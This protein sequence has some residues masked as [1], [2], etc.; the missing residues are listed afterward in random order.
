MVSFYKITQCQNPDDH[1]L[2]NHNSGNLKL[3]YNYIG[4]YIEIDL[5]ATHL[6]HF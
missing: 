3:Y 4:D 2:R 5:K 6:K 1:K